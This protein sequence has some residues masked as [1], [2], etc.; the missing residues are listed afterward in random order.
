MTWVVK[1][2]SMG[3]WLAKVSSLG[4]REPHDAERM[5]YGTNQKPEVHKTLSTKRNKAAAQLNLCGST[6]S[7]KVTRR[8]S[9]MPPKTSAQE[10]AKEVVF[11]GCAFGFFSDGCQPGNKKITISA[12][13]QNRHRCF[14]APG[15]RNHVVQLGGQFFA[16]FHARRFRGKSFK[17]VYC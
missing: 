16:C 13:V 9:V 12:R 4:K 15:A 5:P 14:D 2:I 7:Q 11:K 6:A 17:C 10:N 8:K 1:S 3:T